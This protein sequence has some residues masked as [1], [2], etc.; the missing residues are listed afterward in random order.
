VPRL[1]IVVLP[2]ENLSKDPDQEYFAD[3]NRAFRVPHPITGVLEA[4][5]DQPRGQD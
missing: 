3:F 5:T 4:M 1:S 2:F